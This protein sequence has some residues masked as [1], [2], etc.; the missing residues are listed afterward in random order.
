MYNEDDDEMEDEYDFSEGRRNPYIDSSDE[1]EDIS[2][3]DYR[4]IRGEDGLLTVG[5]VYYN[6]DGKPVGW[7]LEAA[8]PESDNVE[9]IAKELKHMLDAIQKPVFVPPKEN[10]DD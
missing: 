2:N 1:S 3:W 9:E 5:E 8:I 4:L 6:S 7:I 10:S